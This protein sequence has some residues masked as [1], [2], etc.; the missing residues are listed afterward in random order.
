[1]STLRV[2]VMA[3][4][5]PCQHCARPMPWVFGLLPAHRPRAEEYTTTDFPG[6]VGVA[7]AILTAAATAGPVLNDRPAWQSGRSFNPNTCGHCGHQADW[8]AL[9]AITD[10]A[11]YGGWFIAAEG[12]VAVGEWR[13]IRGQGQGVAWPALCDPTDL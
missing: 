5:A 8:H 3:Y 4:E 2:N 12:R 9:D 1:M 13:A 11:Y 10:R 7:R 6:A